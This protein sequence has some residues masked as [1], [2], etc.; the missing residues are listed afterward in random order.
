MTSQQTS[1]HRASTR[2]RTQTWR[3]TWRLSSSC[4]THPRGAE[5]ITQ[6]ISGAT[7]T[8]RRRVNLNWCRLENATQEIKRD[9]TAHHRWD[10]SMCQI[11]RVFCP[12]RRFSSQTIKWWQTRRYPWTKRTPAK[13]IATYWKTCTSSPSNM[14]S[15]PC[16][17]SSSITLNVTNWVRCANCQ[18]SRT[19]LA[20]NRTE[21]RYSA[22][23]Q[24][25]YNP[26]CK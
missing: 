22:Q 3:K 24:H 2:F 5:G 13:S 25:R 18:R 20:I 8:V 1:A 4:L 19:A 15:N 16:L 12:S 9:K 17:R 7:I 21:D 26:F 10:N 23:I 11:I 14:I 6:R